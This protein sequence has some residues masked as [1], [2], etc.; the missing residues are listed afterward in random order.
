LPVSSL[1]TETN[2]G[3]FVVDPSKTID[4]PYSQGNNPLFGSNAGKLCVAMSLIAM[5]LD[6]M[7]STRSSLDLGEI[8][9]GWQ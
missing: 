5:L 8:M 4:A 6:F 2:P 1:G 7:C 3:P 9:N